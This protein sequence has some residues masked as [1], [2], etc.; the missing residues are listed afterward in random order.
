M[1]RAM[2][3]GRALSK[4]ARTDRRTSAAARSLRPVMAS[5]E[6]ECVRE[7]EKE[8]L[9]EEAFGSICNAQMTWIPKKRDI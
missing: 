8:A 3:R 7:Q 5:I 6:L 1:P 2:R 4:C 9:L